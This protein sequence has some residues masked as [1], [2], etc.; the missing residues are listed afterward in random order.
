MLFRIR[1]TDGTIDPASGGTLVGADGTV[2][3]I[4]SSDVST[5]V[6]EHW[7]SPASGATYPSRWRLQLPSEGIDLTLAPWLSD[8]EM[9]VSFPYWEGAVRITG[10]IDGREVSGNG[11]VELTGY[12]RSMRGVF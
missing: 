2:R 12:A 6:L 11:Y 10:T 5:D 4:R 8:Q 1:N 9:R 7:R 3:R